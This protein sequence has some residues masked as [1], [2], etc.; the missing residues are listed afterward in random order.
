MIF[1][2]GSVHY[3][4]PLHSPNS[5]ARLGVLTVRDEAHWLIDMVSYL[6]AVFDDRYSTSVPL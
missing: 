2:V 6:F 3:F 1:S 5:V 4:D